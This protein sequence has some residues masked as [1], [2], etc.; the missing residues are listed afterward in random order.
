MG[1]YIGNRAPNGGPRVTS[2]GPNFKR[3]STTRGSTGLGDDV[4]FAFKLAW[5]CG[6]TEVS[7]SDDVDDGDGCVGC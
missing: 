3:K 1:L 4:S 7:P 5:G 6:T 2:E